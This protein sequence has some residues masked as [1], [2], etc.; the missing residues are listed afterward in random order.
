MDR[1]YQLA[2]S[3]ACWRIACEDAVASDGHSLVGRMALVRAV[4]H[5][6]CERAEALCIERGVLCAL[7]ESDGE[8]NR[9]GR[10]RRR[11]GRTRRVNGEERRAGGA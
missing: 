10:E 1:L 3:V 8:E 7:E 11:R 5:E 2:R 6:V 9:S 4:E